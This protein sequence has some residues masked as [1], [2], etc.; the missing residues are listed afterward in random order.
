MRLLRT[1]ASFA[2]AAAFASLPARSAGA[3]TTQFS[4]DSI[5]TPDAAGAFMEAGGYT[6]ENF[7]TLESGSEF[8]TGDNGNGA[9]FAY[10]PLRQGFGSVRRE[11]RNFFLRSAY[12]SFRAFDDNTAGPVFV[13]VNGYRG[14]DFDSDPVFTRTFALTNTRQF[15]EFGSLGLSEVEFLTDGLESGGRQAVLAV[16]DLTLATVPEPATVVL[17]GAGG[18]VVA[19]VGRTR[20]RSA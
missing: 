18:A 19:L 11:T 7:F 16:D 20:R 12:L 3:Q 17:L 15:V 2:L 9:R 1:A 10:V 4:F 6:F 14:F 8:G 13:T 5:P